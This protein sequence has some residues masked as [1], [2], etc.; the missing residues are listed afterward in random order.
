[1]S[2]HDNVQYHVVYMQPAKKKMGFGTVF[3]LMFVV[4]AFAYHYW[5]II[6]VALAIGL[7]A[8][9]LFCIKEIVDVYRHNKRVD[10][11]QKQRKLERLIAEAKRQDDLLRQ[12]KLE[13]IYGKYQPPRELQ[14]TGIWLVA[15]SDDAAQDRTVFSR[16]S[17]EGSSTGEKSTDSGA[18]DHR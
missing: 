8:L 2:D 1:M 6:L 3:F 18:G 12:G 17:S 15:G 9:L 14:G 13:G 10:K 11:L 16:G 4:P 7:I 5:W